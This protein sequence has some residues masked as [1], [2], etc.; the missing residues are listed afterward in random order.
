[1][2]YP[3]GNNGKRIF[4]NPRK[5]SKYGNRK[6]TVNG[7]R[8]DSVAESEYYRHLIWLKQAGEVESFELQPKFELLPKF[9]KNGKSIRAMK[10]IAD[11]RVT[12]TGGTVEIVDVK[13][14]VTKEFAIKRKLFNYNY[15]DLDLK[16]I[17]LVRG[18]WL[19]I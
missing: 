4:K 16:V 8:F 11:F 10:Y 13:G 1:M 18:E 7:I 17:K 19:E 9:K 14:A 2:R 15:P 3:N 12:Y 5:K 6:V